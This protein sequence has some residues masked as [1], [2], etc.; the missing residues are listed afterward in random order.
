MIKPRIIAVRVYRVSLSASVYLPTF[1]NLTPNLF[2]LTQKRKS[3]TFGRHNIDALCSS[4]LECI[5]RIAKAMQAW[6]MLIYVPHIAN[7]NKDM[8]WFYF[9]CLKHVSIIKNLSPLV[10]NVDSFFFRFSNFFPPMVWKTSVVL[11]LIKEI[12][13][14]SAHRL[15]SSE[16]WYSE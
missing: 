13:R 15:H 11:E 4:Y 16:R 14:S 8:M 2:Y 5:A 1:I 10:Y 7:Y 12:E 3:G 6:R 9:L